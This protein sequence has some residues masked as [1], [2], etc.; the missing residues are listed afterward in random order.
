MKANIESTSKYKL[1]LELTQNEL[2]VI[3][4]ILFGVGGSFEGPRSLVDEL[5]ALLR[6]FPSNK[7]YRQ[8]GVIMLRDEW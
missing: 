3:R 7:A 1:T 6:G 8:S 5:V 4:S 2:D